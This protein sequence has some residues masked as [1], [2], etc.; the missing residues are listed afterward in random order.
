MLSDAFTGT[1]SLGHPKLI[2]REKILLV[3]HVKI[4]GLRLSTKL[5]E[6]RF[7]SGT[8]NHENQVRKSL[9]KKP[10]EL[11]LASDEE[12][13]MKPTSVNIE[14]EKEGVFPPGIEPGTLRVWGARDNRYTTETAHVYSTE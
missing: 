2:K 11:Q 12:K 5:F 1:C 7:R 3:G 4:I 13:M 9:E 10:W 8:Q 6:I 14:T